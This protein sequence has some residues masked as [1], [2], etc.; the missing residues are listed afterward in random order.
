M[1]KL[2]NENWK[3][4]VVMGKK[5]LEGLA[6]VLKRKKNNISR[7]TLNSSSRNSKLA[8]GEVLK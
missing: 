6:H 4:I 1:S 5:R 2:N 7:E 3:N 8:L